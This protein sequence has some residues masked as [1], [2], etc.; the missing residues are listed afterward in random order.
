M[1]KLT[2]VEELKELGFLVRE[3][4][5]KDREPIDFSIEDGED[6]VAWVW[7]E[8]DDPDVECWHPPEALGWYEYD[9]SCECLLCGATGDWH[10]EK[11]EGNVEE[12]HWEG[13]ERV[14]D[15]W[16]K[17]DGGLINQYIKENYDSK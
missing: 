2:A 4:E 12:H 9:M 5:A 13:R 17:G 10:W 15:Q 16:Y 8:V 11:D 6:N 3:S 14:I 7:G 1:N